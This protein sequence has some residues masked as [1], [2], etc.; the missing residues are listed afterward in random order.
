LFSLAITALLVVTYAI[1][2]LTVATSA[3]AACAAGVIGPTKIGTA[4]GAEVAAASIIPVAPFVDELFAAAAG[5]GTVP[6][7]FTVTA[8][9][10][11]S[12]CRSRSI[13]VLVPPTTAATMAIVIVEIAIRLLATTRVSRTFGS[14]PIS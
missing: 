14:V 8:V 4:I 9:V 7:F 5:P 10:T 12:F 3:E 11:D 1:V 13:A 6:A 2:A